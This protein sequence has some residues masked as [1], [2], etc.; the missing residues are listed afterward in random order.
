MFMDL[1]E[2]LGDEYDRFAG[3]ADLTDD[4]PLVT[5][6]MHVEAKMNELAQM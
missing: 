6:M 3:M 5:A 2:A 1:T 4:A